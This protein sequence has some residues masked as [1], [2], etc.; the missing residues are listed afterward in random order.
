MDLR[1][2]RL[3]ILF[4]LIGVFCFSVSL[5]F[6]QIE[7]LK[8][9]FNGSIATMKPFLKNDQWFITSEGY[10]I[11]PRTEDYTPGFSLGIERKVFKN[12]SFE[13]N[14]LY[15]MPP[16]TLGVIDEFSSTGREFLDTKRFHFFVITVSPK[17]Y[18]VQ[19]QFGN[20][21]ISPLAGFGLL[22]NKSITPTFGPKVTWTKTSELV[23]GGRIGFQ[24]RLKKTKFYFNAEV[25]FLSMKIKLRETISGRTL[26]KK[27][28]P[29][30]LLLGISYRF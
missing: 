24:I 5:S 16:A 4:L 27:F 28:G 2:F 25:L 11:H 29:L 14:F 3:K 30:G 22:S 1:L 6:G 9:Q 26:N 8:W 12:I 19:G 18:M 7:E 20:I 10:H 21:Y 17:L 15:G 23:Y 13:L